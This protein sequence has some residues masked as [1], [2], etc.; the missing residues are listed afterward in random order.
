MK[1][2]AKLIVLKKIEKSKIREIFAYL[3]ENLLFRHF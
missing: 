3:S 2:F 1:G